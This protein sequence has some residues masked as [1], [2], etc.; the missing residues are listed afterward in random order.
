M[1]KTLYLCSRELISWHGLTECESESESLSV[2]SDSMRPHGL[3]SPWNSTGH[4]TGVG[5]HSLLP[6]IFPTQASNRGLLHC[7]WIITNWV[8][9][10]GTIRE[11]PMHGLTMHSINAII[12]VLVVFCLWPHPTQINVLLSVF[13]Y[14]LKG[15]LWPLSAT[16]SQVSWTTGFLFKSSRCQS[17]GGEWRVV[18]ERVWLYFTCSF[19]LWTMISSILP[20]LCDF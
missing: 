3:Y 12:Q 2:M 6:G 18:G 16:F 9:L 11:V 8:S 19:S 4:R 15:W 5:S 13:F 14:A 1:D 10:S 7:R 20:W 17:I